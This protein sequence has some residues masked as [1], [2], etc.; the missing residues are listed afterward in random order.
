MAFFLHLHTTGRISTKTLAE[1]RPIDS[2]DRFIPRALPVIKDMAQEIL[3]LPLL[4]REAVAFPHPHRRFDDQSQCWSRQDVRYAG[5]ALSAMK[6]H[7]EGVHRT[8]ATVGR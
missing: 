6:S 8:A 4:M 3:I 1:M 2:F 5:L 7:H